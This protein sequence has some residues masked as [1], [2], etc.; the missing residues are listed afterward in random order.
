[1]VLY[2]IYLIIKNNL[3]LN[4]YHALIGK[5]L[6]VSCGRRVTIKHRNPGYGWVFW[7]ILSQFPQI[8]FHLKRVKDQVGTMYS[9]IGTINTHIVVFIT[10]KVHSTKSIWWEINSNIF[11]CH[12][13]RNWQLLVNNKSLFFK[14]TNITHNICYFFC[15][16]Q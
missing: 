8:K 13:K 1:M 15:Q 16:F 9:I 3:N 4:L 5:L 11:N 10:F 14:K 7:Q 12:R 2:I 6:K